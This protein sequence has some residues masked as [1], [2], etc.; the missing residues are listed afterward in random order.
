MNDEKLADVHLVNPKT[1][2]CVKHRADC[3]KCTT[4]TLLN[5]ADVKEA[6]NEKGNNDEKEEVVTE[7]K[8]EDVEEEKSG[9]DEE[10]EKK[11]DGYNENTNTKNSTC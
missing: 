11:D 2:T 4:Y 1:S 5:L 9:D 10:K 6:K 7:E 3:K 8:K